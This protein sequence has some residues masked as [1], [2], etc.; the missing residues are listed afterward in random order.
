MRATGIPALLTALLTLGTTACKAKPEAAV[1]HPG[2][3]RAR[4]LYTIPVLPRSVVTDTA[5]ADEAER[6]TWMVET[7]FDSVTGFYRREL[8]GLGWTLV[9]DE[10]DSS[11]VDL[12]LQ[13]GGL[14]LE[15]NRL[16]LWGHFQRVG[17]T[18][19]EYT[20]IAS[21]DTTTTPARAVPPQPLQAHPRS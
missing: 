12:Y 6:R 8:R 13:K 16:S 9:S 19:T 5:G 1:A 17:P 2:P 14:G 21:A 10:G 15:R 7:P 3:P 18:A 20:L 11:K 4:I